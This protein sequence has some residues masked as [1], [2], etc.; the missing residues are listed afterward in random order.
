MLLGGRVETNRP[1]DRRPGDVKDFSLRVGECREC[2][3]P[4]GIRRRMTTPAAFQTREVLSSFRGAWLY[5]EMPSTAPVN[6]LEHLDA[7]LDTILASFDTSYAWRYGSVKA[8]LR[9]LYEKAKRE[10]WNGTTQLAWDTEVDPERGILPEAVNPLIGYAPYDRLSQRDKDR[11]RHAQ[12][13]LQ[14]SQF[15]HGEQGAMI[16]ASQLV[17]AVPWTDAKFYASTQT[18]D[19][20]RHVEVFSRYLTE[21]LAWQWPV[22]ESLK[23]LLDTTI[24]DSR[25]DLKYLGMQIIIE[26]LAMAAFGNLWQLTTEPLLKDLIHY[27]M[28]DESRHVAFGVLSLKDHYHDMPAAE[29]RDRE[30]FVIAACELM[31]DRLVGD[32]IATYMGWNRDEVRHQVLGS[33]PAMAFRQMLFARVVPN[34][35]R[36]GLLVPRVRD[37]FER[38]GILQFEDADPEAQDRALG[39]A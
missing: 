35:K 26:G 23:E 3:R 11:L 15:L 19:E 5:R 20:A 9:D 24:T 4:L 7:E 2:L 31:R 33:A 29:R 34:L 30:D 22:N 10:Q 25:W 18:M 16:V 12:L 37:A 32:Q 28:R 39:L 6:Q 14:L 13:A 38:L 17:G 27:V 21:K 36:L 1:Y 8:G